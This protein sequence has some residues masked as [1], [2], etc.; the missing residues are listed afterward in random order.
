MP[1][2]SPNAGYS[3]FTTGQVLTAAQVQ[4]NLQN[5]TIMYFA[6]AAARDAA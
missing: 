4:Y 3:L 1:I 6:S 2:G 5:Q